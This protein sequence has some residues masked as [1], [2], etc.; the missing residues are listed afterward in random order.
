V[1]RGNGHYPHLTT[2][3]TFYLTNPFTRFSVVEEPFTTELKSGSQIQLKQEVSLNLRANRL[4]RNFSK[5]KSAYHIA[6]DAISR[7]KRTKSVLLDGIIS[8]IHALRFNP[9]RPF[10]ISGD[11]FSTLYPRS[12]SIFY[13][14]LLDPRT[15]LDEKDWSNRQR[16][17]LQ[18]TAYAMNAFKQSLSLSTT[19]V[20]VGPHSVSLINIYNPP[21]DTLYSL[22]YALN[23]M[24]S[25]NDIKATYTFP[26]DGT[27]SLQ[28][29]SAA[30]LLQEQYKENLVAQLDHY[31]KF[32]TN[33]QTGLVKKDILLSG[34]K[35]IS[36]RQSAF[37]DNVILW[38]TQQLAQQLGLVP[39]DQAHLDTL[40][41]S[42]LKTFWSEEMGCFLEDLSPNSLKDHYYSS[43][44][45]IVLQTG[46]LDTKN[47]EER[48]YFEKCV[49]Y[50]Q[51][52][53]LDQPFGLRYQQTNRSEREY[54]IV[55]ILVGDYGGTAIWSHLG[56]EYTKLLVLLY[57]QT[58]KQAYLETAKHQVDAYTANIIKYRCYPEVYDHNGN[59]LEHFFYK[60]VCQTGWVVSY[61]QAK[62]MVE[63]ASST[64]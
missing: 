64:P 55:R 39:S 10:L 6:N 11:H 30:Q 42:I 36:M 8:E 38:K 46:F 16:I 18:T 19:I 21:S 20:P 27:Y 44:W 57:L 48:P 2:A 24:Q 51:K 1:G 12:L 23:A 58:K 14:S 43:D 54:S 13:G 61:E 28:T 62:E 15:A 7:T 5:L 34:S 60:S 26:D 25:T 31:M 47:A 59:M 29:Q 22:L 50:I 40:K 52:E 45:I 49:S 32:V 56:Q 41:K 17:Y 4:Y 37:Y 63:S 9:D 33:P 3:A 35:D 53:K